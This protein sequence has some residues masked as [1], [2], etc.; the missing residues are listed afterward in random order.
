MSGKAISGSVTPL[1]SSIPVPCRGA[2]VSL[3]CPSG[4]LLTW[5]VGSETS[6]DEEPDSREQ[7]QANMLFP[8]CQRGFSG[9]RYNV[10]A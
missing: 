1:L 8:K 6:V 4:Q 7:L 9:D 10:Q 3:L 5:C 2:A